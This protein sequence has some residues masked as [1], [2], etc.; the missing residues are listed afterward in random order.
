MDTNVTAEHDLSPASNES[1][2]YQQLLEQFYE[3]SVARYGADS[4][5]ARIL[6]SRLTADLVSQP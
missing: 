3:G 5:Q 4:P 1:E 6:L 2:L